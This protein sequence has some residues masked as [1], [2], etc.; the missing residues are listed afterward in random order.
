VEVEVEI[1][2][3]ANENRVKRVEGLMAK[4]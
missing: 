3:Q 2:D 4:D 1:D